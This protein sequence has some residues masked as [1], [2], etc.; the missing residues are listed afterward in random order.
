[1]KT[2][3]IED[4]LK[5]VYANKTTLAG[6]LS[7]A[8]GL[9][10]TPFIESQPMCLGVLSATGIS[11]SLGLLGITKLG[12]ETLET[13]RDT[14]KYLEQFNDVRTAYEQIKYKNYCTMVGLRLA[15]KES[16]LKRSLE[17]VK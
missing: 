6:Y 10:M 5:C 1:M 15:I 9:S 16:N 14:R 4:Y 8:A 17:E 11:A 7:L 13:Y 3:I 12:I 2:R